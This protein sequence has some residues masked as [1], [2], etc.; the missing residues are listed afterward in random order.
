LLNHSSPVASMRMAY[1]VTP[2]TTDT[3]VIWTGAGS[4]A[5]RAYII[6]IVADAG[7]SPVGFIP[8]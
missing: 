6:E 5:K 8:I 4:E 1:N 2:A 7:G 3:S